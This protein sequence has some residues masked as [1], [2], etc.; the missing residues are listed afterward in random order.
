MA[1]PIP[2]NSDHPQETRAPRNPARRFKFRAALLGTA[3]VLALGGAY[4]GHVQ[5]PDVSFTSP[6]QAE[7]PAQ[8]QAQAAMQA[9]GPAGFADIV[10]RVKGS[11]VSI[12]VK[13]A[14]TGEETKATQMPDVP[15]NSPLY[16]FFKRFGGQLP[17]EF[18]EAHPHIT[19][20]Q[21]SGFFISADGYIV[22]NNHVV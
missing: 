20:A 1:L 15:P 3:A 8:P 10:S 16:H 22:T 21:G 6:A 13:V 11:V 18:H 9:Q 14:E 7:A 5:M 19:M 17:F 12:K 2:P 4:A